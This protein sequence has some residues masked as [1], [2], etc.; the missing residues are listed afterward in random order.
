MGKVRWGSV[1]NLPQ[2]KQKT[3]LDESPLDSL[4]LPESVRSNSDYGGIR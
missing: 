2:R 1:T 4:D 3:H